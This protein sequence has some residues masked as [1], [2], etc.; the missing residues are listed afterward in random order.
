MHWGSAWRF[1]GVVVQR[2]QEPIHRDPIC[3]ARFTPRVAGEAVGAVGAI[4]A[5]SFFI[6]N[7]W[8]DDSDEVTE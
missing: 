5:V 1:D 6:G 7:S 4:P 8:G 3:T 2:S